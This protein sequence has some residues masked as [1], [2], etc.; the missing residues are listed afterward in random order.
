MSTNTEELLRQKITDKIKLSEFICNMELEFEELTTEKAV[1]RIP[2][3]S[4]FLNP[5]GSVHG[6][7]LYSLADTVAGSLAA[8]CGYYCTTAEGSM[9]FFEPAIDTEYVYCNAFC[10]RN[11]KH[12]VNIKIEIR[13][14][15]GNLLDDASFNYFKLNIPVLD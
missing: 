11:G 4:K 14:D 5:Y 10:M 8:M 13:D 1:A 7:F 12:L 9:N 3:K 2:F 15:K 6:G